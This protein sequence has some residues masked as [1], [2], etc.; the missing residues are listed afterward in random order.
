MGDGRI[1]RDDGRNCSRRILSRTREV[2]ATFAK[3]QPFLA[4]LRGVS[5]ELEFCKHRETV[6]MS[7]PDADAI[8]TRRRAA[9]A[10]AAKA[11][12]TQP[13]A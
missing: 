4:E 8:L 2:F 13:N 9:I 7:A 1:P 3:V 12:R 6:V 11:R 5:G 10:A